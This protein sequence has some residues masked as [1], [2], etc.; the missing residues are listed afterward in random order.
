M[1]RRSRGEGFGVQPKLRI[2]MGMYVSAAQ[3]A[4]Q[5]YQRALKVRSLIRRDFEAAFDPQGA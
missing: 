3:Y 5:Y 2:L 1:Y 4:E